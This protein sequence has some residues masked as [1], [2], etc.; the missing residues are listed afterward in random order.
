MKISILF[1][2][3]FLINSYNK[4]NEDKRGINMKK[5]LT[6][7]MICLTLC[8]VGLIAC[9]KQEH[10]HTYSSEWSFD[11]THHWHT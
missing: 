6:F 11:K 4:S 9:D 5:I 3:T 8:S 10:S 7:L 2:D 1:F